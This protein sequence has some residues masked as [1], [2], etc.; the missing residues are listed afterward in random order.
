MQIK[1]I[2]SPSVIIDNKRL[3]VRPFIRLRTN[4]F[5]IFPNIPTMNKGGN[6]YRPII[7]LI[8]VTVFVTDATSEQFGSISTFIVTIF[9][10][11]NH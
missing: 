6:M 9:P 10:K 3:V 2:K 11:T 5:K 4:K 1:Q 8:G 7:N